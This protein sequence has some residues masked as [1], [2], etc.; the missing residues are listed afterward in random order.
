MTPDGSR[1][2]TNPA[3]I[4]TH[5]MYLQYLID[6]GMLLP[7]SPQDDFEHA[8]RGN[9]PLPKAAP[10]NLGRGCV[11]CGRR[12]FFPEGQRPLAAK[13]A[14]TSSEEVSCTKGDL[15]TLLR[16]PPW[17]EDADLVGPAETKNCRALA[18]GFAAGCVDGLPAAGFGVLASWAGFGGVWGLVCCGQAACSGFSR[19]GIC[20][21]GCDNEPSLALVDSRVSM[22]VQQAASVNEWTGGARVFGDMT[23]LDCCGSNFGGGH[24]PNLP[25]GTDMYSR[26]WK[27]GA[28]SNYYH[29]RT[30]HD[31][32]VRKLVLQ[33]FWC[34]NYII[35]GHKSVPQYVLG[36]KYF[37]SSQVRAEVDV[38]DRAFEVCGSLLC[39]HGCFSPARTLPLL[40]PRR[41][42]EPHG[43]G[44]ILG[45]GGAVR[46]CEHDGTLK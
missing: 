10:A 45:A 16:Q 2:T 27:R 44:T 5:V 17:G 37:A 28:G 43:R 39:L 26:G 20:V 31:K 6:R 32:I 34:Y 11:K 42:G 25:F 7:P 29:C 24:A 13:G 36:P 3:A 38:D 30:P 40:R 9:L 21:V 14:T 1:V 12:C 4:Q 19:C 23:C 46:V 8:A 15:A 41:R 33:K 35:V 18:E 22:P